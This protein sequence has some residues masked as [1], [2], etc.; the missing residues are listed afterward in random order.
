MIQ[1]RNNVTVSIAIPWVDTKITKDS[2]MTSRRT[3]WSN[4]PHRTI[5][6]SLLSHSLVIYLNIHL[7]S[8]HSST[9]T[10]NGSKCAPDSREKPNRP[11]DCRGR[12]IS[13]L[14]NYLLNCLFLTA[15][16]MNS[17]LYVYEALLGALDDIR[18]LT[19]NKAPDF[20]YILSR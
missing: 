2:M 17:K 14:S 12:H 8:A 9:I 16:L 19:F 18:I 10:R 4:D 15:P 11:V 13:K 7:V 1:T 20:A 3:S 6:Y 5:A